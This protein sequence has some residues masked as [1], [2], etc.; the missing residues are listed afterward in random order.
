M[1]MGGLGRVDGGGHQEATMVLA[2]STSCSWPCLLW[3]GLVHGSAPGCR[4]R[5]LP[6]LP[7]T[8]MVTYSPLPTTSPPS[9]LTDDRK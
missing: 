9:R 5:P 2:A 4:L 7:G 8:L 3:A 6:G 1:D